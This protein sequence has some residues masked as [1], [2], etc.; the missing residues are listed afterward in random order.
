MNKKLSVF[1][2]PLLLP[3]LVSC[4]PSN[5]SYEEVSNKDGSMSYEIFVRSFYDSDG[6][7]TGDLNGVTQ[8][9][10]YLY[11]LGIKTIWLMPIQK[12]PSYHG[13]DVS[14]YYTINSQL[15]TLDDFDNL[16]KEADK[17]NIDIMLDMVFN[18][19][20]DRHKYFTDSYN[21]YKNNNTESTSK[22][23]WF[24]WS[25]SSLPGYNKYN[26]LYYE[27]RFSSSMPDFNLDSIGVRNEIENIMKFW[28]K[29]HKVKGFRLDAV[30][31]YYYMNTNKN[32]EFLTWLENT[33]HKYDPNFYMVGEAWDDADTVNT[34][35]KSK[36][37]S[38][39]RFEMAIGGDYY[40]F[41]NL[42]KG[43]ISKDRIEMIEENEKEIK[44]NNPNGYASYFLSNHDQDRVS[45]SFN[46]LENKCAAS[47]LCLMPGTPFMYYGEEIG[48][49][50]KRGKSDMTDA[51]RR[52]PMVWSKDDKVGECKYPEKNTSY[53]WDGTQV[54]KGVNDALKEGYSLVNHYKKAINIRNK[55]PFLKHGVFS[56]L[57]EY[58]TPDG[59]IAYKIALNN[60]YINVYHN[61]SDTSV[62]FEVKGSK[63]V[64]EINTFKTNAKLD[65]DKLTLAPYSSAVLQ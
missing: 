60:D 29:D 21:D 27:S 24:N 7:G 18:H 32:I 55:Y 36:L 34:Y 9:L 30:L 13:Y 14:N 22:A 35:H 65:G 6:N 16:V 51:L 52:L 54:E 5:Y 61:F 15:G 4:S 46:E 48:L 58:I 17:Y 26:D 59:V 56:S 50:G 20:S 8:K 64:D 63:I 25:E 33:A 40:S 57:M 10:P 31:Y 19:C 43:M 12:S 62:T 23:D 11:D 1:L 44:R 37:D 53:L 3:A 49:L 39:F 45:T 47:I 2:I 41:I 38:F 42:S 28:I